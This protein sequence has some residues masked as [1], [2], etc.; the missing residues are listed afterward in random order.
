MRGRENRD[1]WAHLAM[2]QT[3]QTGVT[4]GAGTRDS[5]QCSGWALGKSASIS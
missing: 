5:H 3:P 1:V 2:S 4:H